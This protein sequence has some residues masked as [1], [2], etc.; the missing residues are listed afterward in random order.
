MIK[1]IEYVF[2]SQFSSF[3]RILF[4]FLSSRLIYCAPTTFA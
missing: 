2:N 4:L 3:N 1:Y